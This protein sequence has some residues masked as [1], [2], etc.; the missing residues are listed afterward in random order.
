LYR[1]SSEGEE[2][3]GRRSQTCIETPLHERKFRISALE[4]GA[5]I[6]LCIWK[7]NMWVVFSVDFRKDKCVPVSDKP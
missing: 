4:L 2:Q 7:Y 3:G 6:I 5:F 1:N